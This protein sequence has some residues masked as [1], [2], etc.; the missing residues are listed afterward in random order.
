MR[1]FVTGA[2]GFIGSAL[3]PELLGHGHQVL[4]LSRSDEDQ[5]RLEAAGIHVHPGSLDDTET[6]RSGAAAAD[7]VIHLAFKHDFADFAGAVN[8]DQQAIAAMG[9][10]LVGSGKPL[11]IASPVVGVAPGRVA[12]EQDVPDPAIN[13]RARSAQQ[14]LALRERGVRSLVVR[15]AP[16]VHDLGDGGFVRTLV[17]VARRQGVSGYVAGG[18]NRWSA[19]HRQDA[20]RLFRLALESAPAGTV[21]HAVAEEGISAREIAA[22]IGLHLPL[23]SIANDDVAAHF[24][25]I[26]RFFSA[27]APASSAQT[28]AALGWGP[29]HRGLMDDLEHGDYFRP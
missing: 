1:V 15:L 14:T 9:E 8:T 16:T 21:L 12:T 20:A 7:G 22:T 27:D 4:G 5:A 13:L 11:V 28:R 17:E 19:V 6:L 24:G 23:Q 10:A 3:L 2:S 25:W 26:G 29:T 18:Q